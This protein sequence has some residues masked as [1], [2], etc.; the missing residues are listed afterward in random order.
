MTI[1]RSSSLPRS[2]R[3]RNKVPGL[4]RR[5][6]ESPAPRAVDRMGNPAFRFPPK[7][8]TARSPLSGSDGLPANRRRRV[9]EPA[10]GSRRATRPVFPLQSYRYV[11]P[12]P[13]HNSLSSKFAWLLIIVGR[14]AK[15]VRFLVAAQ[16]HSWTSMTTIEQ[17]LQETNR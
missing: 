11:F 2:K 10:R 17:L 15:L 7:M 6:R 16:M 9:W 13:P 1:I 3:W 5:T 4:S 8:R 14:T 12:P